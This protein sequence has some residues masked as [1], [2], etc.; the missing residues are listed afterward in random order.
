M[1][2]YK[3]SSKIDF[4]GL[5]GFTC[6][7]ANHFLNFLTYH[8]TLLELKLL[9]SLRYSSLYFLCC[10]CRNSNHQFISKKSRQVGLQKKDCVSVTKAKFCAVHN[11]VKQILNDH[12]YFQTSIFKRFLFTKQSFQKK[13]RKDRIP[14]FETVADQQITKEDLV[15]LLS[16]WYW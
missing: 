2:A 7:P 16:Q 3:E 9:A 8:P 4:S 15:A 14:Y 1:T 10:N 11:G 6:L 12:Y 13:S 5:L